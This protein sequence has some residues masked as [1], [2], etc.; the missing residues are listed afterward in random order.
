M[1]QPVDYSNQL[2]L[3]GFK[4]MRP[5]GPTY[6]YHDIACELVC[7]RLGFELDV[8]VLVQEPVYLPDAGL[9]LVSPL[10]EFNMKEVAAELIVNSAPLPV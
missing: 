1:G 3:L 7:S 2:R 5:Q 10:H 6:E 4:K 9:G 8:P